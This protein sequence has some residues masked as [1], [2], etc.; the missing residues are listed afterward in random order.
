MPLVFSGNRLYIRRPDAIAY[1]RGQNTRGTVAFYG[2][3]HGLYAVAHLNGGGDGMRLCTAD[4]DTLC[5]LGALPAEVKAVSLGE[6]REL[7]VV[8][9]CGRVVA[10]GKLRA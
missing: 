7:M 6:C 3:W 9:G 8:D 1:I 2:R 10:K 4:G 5:R